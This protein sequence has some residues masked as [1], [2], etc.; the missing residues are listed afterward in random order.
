MTFWR[1]PFKELDEGASTAPTGGKDRVVRV[2]VSST[3]RDMHEEREELIKFTFPELRKR[4]R[5]RQVEFTEVDLRWGVTDEQKAEGKVLPICLAEIERCRPYF[6]GLLGE[7]YGYVP[8]KIDEELSEI[9][10]WLK[11]HKEKSITEL[12]ILYGVLKDPEMRR[13]SFFYFRDPK[14]SLRVEGEL[15][16]KPDYLPEPKVSIDKLKSLKE[17]IRKHEKSYPA[18]V[19]EDFPDAKTLGNLV[20]E[21]LW[22]VIDER[23]PK[24]EIPTALERERMEHK[25]FAEARR[26]VYIGGEEYFKKLDEHVAGDG[27]PLVLLGKSG[28][29]KSALIAN[30]A[31]KYRKKHPDDFMVLHFIGSTLDSADYVRI[32][33][34]I[35]EEIKERYEPES[36]EKMKWLITR[37]EDKI[38]TDPKKVVE[39]FPLWLARVSAK[40]KF[41]LIL[42][43]LN[44]LEDRDNAP[45]LDWLP[46]YFPPNT[47]VILSTLPSR[48]LESLKRRN[49]NTLTVQPIKIDERKQ[50]IE[51][52]LEQYRKKLS[53]EHTERIASAE[54]SSNPLYLRT[55]LEELRVFGIYKE[56]DNRINHYLKAD[57]VDGLF[58]LVLER[59]ES[60][61]EYEE[62]T[63]GLVKN[64]MSLIWVSRS[65]LSEIELLDLLGTDREPLQRAYWSPLYLAVEESLVS[66][67]GLINFFHDFLRKAVE[68]RYLYESELK[69][70]A[71]IRLADYFERRELDDRKVDELPWQLRQSER[72]KR[73]KDCITDMEM[74]LRLRTEK[75]Q[76]E[77][78]GYW[79]LIGNRFDMVKSYNN[80]LNKYEKTLPTEEELSYRLNEVS[81]FFRLNAR[82]TKAEPLLKRSLKIIE[83]VLGKDH[84]S[85]A[86]FLNNLAELY[87]A[88]GRYTE[89]EPLLKRS[90]KIIEKVLGK[91]H[92]SVATFLNNLAELY[93]DQGRYTEAEPLLKR[94]L[95]IS[96]KVLGKDH[97]NVATFLNNL[98]ELYR[99]QGMYT[100]AEPLL[101]RSLKI[102]EKVLGKD[103][104]SVATFLNNLAGLYH[105]QGMY[106]EA[107][108]LLKRSLKIIEKVLGKDHPNVAQSLNNLAALYH[109]QGMYTEAEPLLKRS[110]KIR[111][112]VLGKDH[113]NV[114]LSLNNLAG[115]YRD[116]GMYTEA[117]PLL[118]RSLKIREKVLGKD[119][120]N[121]ATFLNNLAE[122]YHYQGMYTE[123][124]PLLKRSLKIGEKVLGKDHPNVAQSLNNL[125]G[126][127]RAQGMYTEAEPLY[128]RSLK[129]REKVLGKD[130]PNVAQSLNNL[131]VLYHNQG[132]Y[133][134]A[135]PLYKRSLKI[136]E[137]VLG[138]DHPSV[139]T[140]LNNLAELYH[141]QGMYTE[142]EPLYKRSLK[143]G[144]K[145]LGKDHPSV[146]TSLNNLAALY[147]DQGRYTEVEPLY[148]R[149]V[150]ITE[151]VLG[152][153]HT[154][155]KLFR[156]NLKT[157]QEAM[158]EKT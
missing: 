54:Q 130:H 112:K 24:E 37:K 13:L 26:K 69:K 51:K 4:C 142:A 105:D 35:M 102:G 89:A 48:S 70:T 25:A 80:M 132:M 63:K 76:Y 125:A 81:L 31:K 28:S 55:L 53:K 124:E 156:K 97:P 67:A 84:P 36:K 86:T 29:G 22:K 60:D 43:S 15:A 100:E 3:F 16:K 93:H 88:Q 104:P 90:L 134:E 140:S 119:H 157:C 14:T 150:R 61:Y 127:Y 96:E 139:A 8:E 106:T 42:D 145:V 118:K 39:V 154:K 153:N 47:R 94:S 141:D 64:A 72:W 99:A 10:P 56:L 7:R 92:P 32:L 114:A 27:L 34:R 109:D 2:F 78:M 40:G 23:F 146:A 135:E 77:L 115:L 126:L 38:P 58:E 1:K 5:E 103:H 66:R 68:D 123:A 147:Y 19:R 73:L 128:K 85:V 111:E 107:E 137:K 65:G 52:Y 152:S 91:D 79:L 83:K 136:R 21:D 41:I 11:A 30:W 133:T 45:D 75:K 143:I 82:Y 149:A 33:R 62:E 17:K 71:H 95:K 120:P 155:T 74:F 151:A 98:A 121:V 6:I 59:L 116:Q 50:F 101:K 144:E 110:L 148:K 131:A 18:P 87:R 113:P 46:E 57:T 12:E 129:I 158:R 49:Y 9:Q 138:K 117:E 44:Q 20:L 122:L 108:P